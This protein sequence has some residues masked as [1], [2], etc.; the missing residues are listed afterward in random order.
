MDDFPTVIQSSTIGGTKTQ[1]YIRTIEMLG[2]IYEQKGLYFL[3][4]FLYELQ[5]DR[6]DILAM[7]EIMKPNNGK[8]SDMLK[9]MDLKK[10]NKE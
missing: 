1:E 10:Q 3:L 2:E 9:A 5:Y 8:I 6:N 4:A 7:M